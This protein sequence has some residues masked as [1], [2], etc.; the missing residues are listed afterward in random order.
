MREYIGSTIINFWGNFFFGKVM[1]VAQSIFTLNGWFR[2]F[3]AASYL[4]LTFWAL[5]VAIGLEKNYFWTFQ[6]INH[7]RPLVSH[8]PDYFF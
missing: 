7:L 1:A 3:W 4:A 2:L 6:K 8:L 5:K